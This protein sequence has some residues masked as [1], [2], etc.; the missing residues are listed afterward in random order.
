MF[1][2]KNW[3]WLSF[4]GIDPKKFIGIQCKVYWPLD[5]RWYSGHVLGYN[6]EAGRHHVK[7]EDDEEENLIL[8]NERF[9]FYVY[10][11]EMD[12]LKLTCLENSSETDVIDVNEMMV[13]A[14]SLDDCQVV[15]CGDM[16]WAKLT[17]HAVW[18]AIVPDESSGFTQRF[19][20][21][22]WRK[23]SPSAVLRHL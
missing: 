11:E 2:T 17:G 18:P 16:I 15:E 12:S 9:K 7:Y 22:I 10:H 4:E 14:A 19:K 5:A 13:L 23:V 21:N 6:L 1:R 3:V 20:Q 8:A